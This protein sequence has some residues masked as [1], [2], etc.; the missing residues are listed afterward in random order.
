MGKLARWELF[1]RWLPSLSPRGSCRP[2]ARKHLPQCLHLCPPQIPL[3]TPPMRPPSTPSLLIRRP[4]AQ[5][6]TAVLRTSTSAGTRSLRCALSMAT[7]TP[8]SRA[9][10]T[11]P[12]VASPTEP[13]PRL[14]CSSTPVVRPAVPPTV[15]QRPY[16]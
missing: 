4:H 2:P 15:T 11:T 6:A 7:G 3:L 8:P 14:L 1:L 13:A 12:R 16:A 5:A 10:A 9:G